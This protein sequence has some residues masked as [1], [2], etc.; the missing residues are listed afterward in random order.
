MY[1]SIQ[2]C[3]QAFHQGKPKVCLLFFYSIQIQLP[4]LPPLLL[5]LPLSFSRRFWG[6]VF[7]FSFFSAIPMVG[8]VVFPLSFDD[9]HNIL[10]TRP[11]SAFLSISFLFSFPFPL[12]CGRTRRCVP[13]KSFSKSKQADSNS[14]SLLARSIACSVGSFLFFF[15]DEGTEREREGERFVANICACHAYISRSWNRSINRSS[16]SSS[17]L[18]SMSLAEGET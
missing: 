15:I 4:Y 7:Y 5:L 10:P 13:S 16:S 18:C 2:S 1:S 11:Y 17:S 8:S 6:V 14:K 12:P 3:R 9:D